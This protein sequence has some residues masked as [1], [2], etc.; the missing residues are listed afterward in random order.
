MS[1]IYNTACET[2]VEAA[3]APAEKKKRVLVVG[4]TP[5]D[6]AAGHRAGAVA[7]AVASGHFTAEQLEASGADFVLETLREPLPG[8]VAPVL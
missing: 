3:F 6:V 8:L 5:L 4:D 2:T 7:V 1:C